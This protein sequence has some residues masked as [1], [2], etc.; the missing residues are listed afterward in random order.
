MYSKS[1]Y[2]WKKMFS[3]VTNFIW[4]IVMLLFMIALIAGAIYGI[5]IWWN[6]FAPEI[7]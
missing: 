3:S 2:A 7:Q 1:Y 6:V 5:K 4:S